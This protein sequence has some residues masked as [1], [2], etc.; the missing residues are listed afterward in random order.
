MAA[1]VLQTREEP[2]NA[3]LDCIHCGL[4]LA[5]C[6]TYLQLGSE[7]DSP[8]GRIY[9][10]NAVKEGRM[11]P[12]SPVFEKHMHM[13]LECRACESACPS[14]V[15]FSLMMNDARTAIRENKKL[16]GWETFFRRLVF[17]VIFPNRRYMH[18][19]F[20]L[21][22]LYQRTGLRY[23]VRGTGMLKFFS[24]LRNMEAMLPEIPKSPGYSLPETAPRRG[25]V[26]AAFFEGCI[27]PEMFGPV[28]E[29]SLRV[30]ERNGVSLCSPSRQTC[31]GALHLHDGE[32]RGALELARRN[33][34]AFENDGADFI[35]VN[36]AGCGAMLKE[37]GLLLKD[38]VA[39]AARARA[40]SARVKDI[41]EL[42]DMLG[43]NRD[44]APL[45][46]KVTYDDPCH[47]LHGQG[48]RAAPRNL[49]KCI[50]GLELAELPDAD[51]CCGSAGI[52]NITHP[53]M[54]GLLIEE[55]IA[56]ILRTGAEIVATGNPGCMLQIQAALRAKDLPIKVVHPVELLDQAYAKSGLSD[57]RRHSA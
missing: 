2:E 33:V 13:C 3:H 37:Y 49:L 8:R 40:F 14:G 26:R 7:V 30:M 38:D 55:K 19:G 47:L 5:V 52:Y 20:R 34:D 10:I 39:Y 24:G 46:L 50:P 45:K 35:I 53:E 23:L 22:R 48:I 1:Q 42:L 15:R 44:M 25:R 56:N 32:I 12:A 41:A 43:I 18:F 36:S 6:P 28:H 57:Y 27:M 21:L 11:A 4:C 51:R 9:L 29:A 54:A 17:E 16:S 31:C